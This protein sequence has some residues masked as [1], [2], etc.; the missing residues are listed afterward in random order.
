MCLG[1]LIVKLRPRII[2]MEQTNGILTKNRGFY[3]EKVI[4]QL[5]DAGYSVRWKVFNTQEYK[6]P[7]ARKRL[8]VVAAW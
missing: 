8:F 1:D 7:Q 4:R 3:F 5:I 6:V 2:T